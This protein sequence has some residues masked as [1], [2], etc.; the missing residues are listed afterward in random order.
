MTS[1]FSAAV[2]RRRRGVES[3]LGVPSGG[4][5][6]SRGGPSGSPRR[7]FL[8]MGERVRQRL[9]HQREPRC[10]S[11]AGA[12]YQVC[13]SYL[14]VRSKQPVVAGQRGLGR[15][16][17]QFDVVELGACSATYNRSDC[18]HHQHISLA[19]DPPKHGFYVRIW[20]ASLVAFAAAGPTTSR[21]R[22]CLAPTNTSPAFAKRRHHH[23]RRSPWWQRL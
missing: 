13:A 21:R 6:D 9:G 4:A 20:T 18:H 11:V 15:R 17:Q 19:C 22:R 2:L 12:W 1:P 5:G 16:Q 23:Q 7:S 10:V 3:E 8:E 14:H